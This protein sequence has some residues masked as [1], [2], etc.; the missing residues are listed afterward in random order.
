MRWTVKLRVMIARR[1]WILWITSGLVVALVAAY[2]Y[3][4][5]AALDR[6]RRTW[7]QTS[8][9]WVVTAPVAAG[10]PLSEAAVRRRDLPVA[11]LPADAVT[12][13]GAGVDRRPATIVRA[14]G[15]GDIVTER[16]LATGDAR[17]ALVPEGHAVVAVPAPDPP[18]PA[19]VGD[20]V[21][22]AVDVDGLVHAVNGRL[23]AVDAGGWSVALTPPDAAL[24]ATS[25]AGSLSA[26]TIVLCAPSGCGGAG[27]S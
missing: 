2:L 26:A 4:G 8:A 11:A 14:L 18:P 17:F 7:G 16:D 19:L 25:T 13:D 22:V 12:H 23:I 6:E 3:G 15:P 10:T 20:P 21:Q 5:R 27:S 1:P 24:V 9:V